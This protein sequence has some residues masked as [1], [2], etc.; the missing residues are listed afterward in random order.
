MPSIPNKLDLYRLSVQDPEA[1]ALLLARIYR[2][3]RKR[4]AITLKEDYAGTSAISAAWVAS[5][6]DRQAIAVDHDARVL[7]WGWRWAQR[8]LAKPRLDDLH[9]MCSDVLRVRKP[10]VDVV[11]ALNFSSLYNRDEQSMLTYMRAAR[12]SL[13]PGGVFMLDVFGG[14]GSMRVGRFPRRITPPRR[15]GLKP[16]TYIWDQ[17]HYEPATSMIDCRIHYRLHGG[18]KLEN[19]FRY[20]WRL[21]TVAELTD[22]MLKAGYASAHVWCE[23]WDGKRE[24]S[25]GEYR[26]LTKLGPREDFIAYIVG[27]K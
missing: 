14:P 25:D 13:S 15:E 18:I 3:H 20:N 22:L 8:T 6:P 23:G 24:E 7:R 27:L 4:D 16:F 2:R 26:P 1:E 9:L 12:A 10:T 19:V 5:H 21:W 17:H 11:A